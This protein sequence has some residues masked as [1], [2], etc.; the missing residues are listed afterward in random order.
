MEDQRK[1]ENNQTFA[2]LPNQQADDEQASKG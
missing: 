2:I 1:P